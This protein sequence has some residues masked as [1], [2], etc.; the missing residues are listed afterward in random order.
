MPAYIIIQFLYREERASLHTTSLYSIFYPISGPWKPKR[1]TLGCHR[2][3]TLVAD[4]Q[5]YKNTLPEIQLHYTVNVDI[6]N[7]VGENLTYTDALITAD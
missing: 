1:V 3:L 7:S 4:T 5:I 2:R 6:L